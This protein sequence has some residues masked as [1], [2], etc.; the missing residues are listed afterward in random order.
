MGAEI[1][2]VKRKLP[3]GLVTY[4]YKEACGGFIPLQAYYQ[5]Q[6]GYLMNE[7]WYAYVFFL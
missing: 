1:Q 2:L 3:E 4:V 5:A 7:G 6:A